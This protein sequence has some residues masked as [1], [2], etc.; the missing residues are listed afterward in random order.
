ML[1]AQ[2]KKMLRLSAATLPP[3]LSGSQ[4]RLY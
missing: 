1:E 3:G 2:A 4:E